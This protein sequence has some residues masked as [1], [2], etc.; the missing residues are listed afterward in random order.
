MAVLLELQC[1][2]ALPL[3]PALSQHTLAT[4]ARQ[5]IDRKRRWSSSTC[6]TSSA[7]EKPFE[8]GLSLAGAVTR[9]SATLVLKAAL[10]EPPWYGLVVIGYVAAFGLLTIY[11]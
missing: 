2:T 7:L 6:L 11:F 5:F 10:E 9:V 4:I 1:L 8:E 3:K